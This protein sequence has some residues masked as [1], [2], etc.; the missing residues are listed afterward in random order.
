V[1]PHGDRSTISYSNNA[2]RSL[3]V[4]GIY[5]PSTLKYFRRAFL[6]LHFLRLDGL[7]LMVII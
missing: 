5:K 2:I 1:V 7:R 4:A 3:H 6:P